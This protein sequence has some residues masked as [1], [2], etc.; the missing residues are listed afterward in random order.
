MAQN[1]VMELRGPT[2]I[3]HG[4]EPGFKAKLHRK[5]LGIILQTAREYGVAL[6]VTSLVDQMFTAL[7]EDGKGEWDHSA[8]LTVIEELSN[9]SLVTA[10][11]P[12]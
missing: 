12:G 8:L 2:M 10:E 9:H 7:I 4:F 5:D 1:R 6:P 3:Q 11:R